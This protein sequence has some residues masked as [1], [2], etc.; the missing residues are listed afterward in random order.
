MSTDLL[1]LLNGQVQSAHA[2]QARPP[3]VLAKGGKTAFAG[4]CADVA[5]P[6]RSPVLLGRWDTAPKL[7]ALRQRRLFG[8]SVLRCSAPFTARPINRE[9]QRQ[10]KSQSQGNQQIQCQ[11]Q[12]KSNISVGFILRSFLFSSFPRRRESSAVA[13][14]C[15]PTLHARPWIPAFAGMTT[16]C[17]PRNARDE[18]RRRKFFMLSSLSSLSL[19]SA[20]HLI[21]QRLKASRA[22]ELGRAEEAPL[23][24]RSEFG[25]RARSSEE[26]RGPAA[27]RLVSAP[28]VLATFA[29]TKVARARRAR[30]LCT[31][32]QIKHQRWGGYS[33]A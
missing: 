21:F 26:R 22:P 3:F 24:E 6:P 1:F 16:L 33:H 8:P 11:G 17:G 7:A 15:V 25:R 14:P 2:L 30:K 13:L 10:N 5:A 19:C 23:S 12:S 32:L 20:L 27:G 29:K 31:S 18:K 28:A 9:P 4:A